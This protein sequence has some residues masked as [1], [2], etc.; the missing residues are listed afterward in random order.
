MILIAANDGSEPLVL[1][2]AACTISR[3]PQMA[4]IALAGTANSDQLTLARMYRSPRQKRNFKPPKHTA[5]KTVFSLISF[6]LLATIAHA[7]RQVWPAGNVNISGEYDFDI[8]LL[9][10]SIE[11]G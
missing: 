6:R 9:F 10:G 1:D 7:G 8:S 4:D 3:N 2:A 11:V 5:V